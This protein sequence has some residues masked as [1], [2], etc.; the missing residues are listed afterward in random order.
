VQ[1]WTNWYVGKDDF[2]EQSMAIA[3]TV[4]YLSSQL[5]MHVLAMM[6]ANMGIDSKSIHR[7]AMKNEY[8]FPV[9]CLTSRA[10]HY[11]AYISAREGNV[12]EEMD[13]E[14]KGVALRNSNVPKAIMRKLRKLICDI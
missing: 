3:N 11:Y 9:F 8:S 12:Y 1:Y 2:S 4:I 5:I 10:K 6:S 7:I 13:V 14:L